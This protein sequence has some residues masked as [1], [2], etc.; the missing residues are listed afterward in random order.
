MSIINRYPLL[1]IL[2]AAATNSLA[3]TGWVEQTSGSSAYLLD[4]HFTDSYEGWVVGS[5]ATI[6]HTSNAGETWSEQISPAFATFR[7]VSFVD[8]DTGWVAGDLA[9]VHTVDGGENWL[10]QDPGTSVDLTGVHFLD[11]QSGWACGGENVYP[12]GARRIIIHTN[13]GGAN[14]STQL[15]ETQ[16]LPLLDIFFSDLLNGCAVGELGAIY[17]TSDGGL[18]WIDRSLSS[19]GHLNDVCFTSPGTGYVASADGLILKTVDAGVTWTEQISG[20]SN[21][22][23]GIDF[24]DTDTGWAVGGSND[25][26]NILNTLDGGNL[27]TEQLCEIPSPLVAVHFSDNSNGWAVGPYG[28]IVH[29]AD[30]GGL[31]IEE[32]QSAQRGLS[33]IGVYPNP[34]AS[35]VSILFTT[36]GMGSVEVTI[37]DISGRVLGVLETEIRSGGVSAVQ[38]DGT[39]SE[40]IQAQPGI[41]FFTFRVPGEQVFSA[42]VTL[43]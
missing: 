17:T 6:L 2:A 27:W 10:E 39:T 41:F 35:T 33:V 30:G 40:G 7:S 8:S 29:T 25:S 18:N 13:D 15:Y 21:Y 23:G 12:A 24:S 11:S 4:V 16:K 43:L 1:I 3:Q 34:F 28:V 26:C 19:T 20:T 32:E 5:V 9:L 31:G 22:L 14:W 42:R 38:W 36:G 37:H